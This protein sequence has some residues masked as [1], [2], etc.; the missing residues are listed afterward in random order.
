MPAACDVATTDRSSMPSGGRRTGGSSPW[1]LPCMRGGR[2]RPKVT[3]ALRHGVD[4]RVGAD[5]FPQQL[6]REVGTFRSS[7]DL[8]EIIAWE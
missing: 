1:H 4:R 3:I 5:E 8:T 7:H 6:V 2:Q